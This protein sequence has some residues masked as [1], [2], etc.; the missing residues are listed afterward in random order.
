MLGPVR[1]C[2]VLVTDTEISR[3]SADSALISLHGTSP[4]KLKKIDV[5]VLLFEASARYKRITALVSRIQSLYRRRKPYL[6]YRHILLSI[7]LIQR[8]FRRKQLILHRHD[9]FVSKY[10]V[11]VQACIRRCI[12]YKK[13]HKIKHNII[14]IQA[15][16]RMIMKRSRFLYYRRKCILIQT[17]IRRILTAKHEH[18]NRMILQSEYMTEIFY[19]WKL[20]HIPLIYRAYFVNKFSGSTY[21]L[22]SIY[23]HELLRLFN[24]IGY[25]NLKNVSSPEFSLIFRQVCNNQLNTTNVTSLPLVKDNAVKEAAERQHI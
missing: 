15:V 25:P 4:S 7:R 23:K 20:L 10:L 22:L 2:K 18:T 17:I 16:W 8:R 14:L 1:A 13:Y 24:I 11:K 3:V 9:I 5:M 19:L 21:L 12:A 6:K